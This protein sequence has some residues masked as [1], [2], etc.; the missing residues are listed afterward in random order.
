M[1]ILQKK[2]AISL[3]KEWDQ[4]CENYFQKRKFLA[5]C[6]RYNPCQQKYYWWLFLLIIPHFH[7]GRESRAPAIGQPLVLIGDLRSNR[8]P[9]FALFV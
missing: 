7:K 4:K 1:I 8:R 6:E 9:V 5:Y 3:P 2:N